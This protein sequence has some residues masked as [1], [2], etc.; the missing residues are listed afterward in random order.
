MCTHKTDIQ[1]DE[2]QIYVADL[3]AYNAGHLHG[4]WIDATEDLEDMENQINTMLKASPVFDAE[5][6]AIHDSDGFEGCT[7]GE[8]ES[9][10][11]V[12]DKAVFIEEHGAL[13]AHVLANFNGDK[14]ETRKCMEES[15]QGSF[16]SLADYAQDLM[17]D[18]GDIPEHLAAY[19]DYES[20]A[21]DMDLNGDIFTIETA[22]NEVHVFWNQ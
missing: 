9:L 14:E 4:V 13:G 20:M 8:Y 16:K 19:I 22:W 3:A 6:C 11:S 17:E 1:D 5:E 15:Y 10:D 21:R 12:H 7:I 2:I 18:T